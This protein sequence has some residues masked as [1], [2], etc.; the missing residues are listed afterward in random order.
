MARGL[1]SRQVDRGSRAF[2]RDGH[3]YG[4]AGSWAREHSSRSRSFSA[5]SL[6]TTDHRLKKNSRRL[7]GRRYR[8]RDAASSIRALTPLSRV[9]E[10]EPS[11]GLSLSQTLSA[12]EPRALS[13]SLVD[14]MTARA[15][16]STIA[17]AGMLAFSDV[18]AT[19]GRLVV[20]GN[21]HFV[22]LSVAL[23]RYSATPACSRQASNR[24]KPSKIP[25][26][27]NRQMVTGHQ[28]G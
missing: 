16:F 1:R 4:R 15:R 18:V 26:S 28:A 3:Q 10:A 21:Q 24:R 20:Q 8:R 5:S 6:D 11:L 7:L 25:A 14:T 17:F 12:H 2:T 19:F 22:G 9:A 27:G 23:S 13:S